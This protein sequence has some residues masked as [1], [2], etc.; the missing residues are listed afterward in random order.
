MAAQARSR[1]GRT[2]I[3]WL[4]A[5]AMLALAETASADPI[6]T[7]DRVKSSVVAVG[8]YERTRS[9]GFQFRAT[10]FSVGDGTLIATNAHVLPLSLDSEHRETLAILV[11][12]RGREPQMREARAIAVDPDTDLALLKI[13]GAPLPA[14]KLRTDG[15]REGQVVLFTG[16]PI[17]AALGIIP[18]THRGMISAITPIAIPTPAA[19]NLDPRIIRRLTTG[20]FMV[21]QLD[22]TAYPGNSGS[23][24]YDPDTGEVFAIINMVFVKSTRESMLKDPSGITYA[25]PARHLRA[26]LE[27]AHG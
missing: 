26:L 22:A 16:F 25:I 9:P 4:F 10:G 1:G 13:D 20:P 21:Y 7:I 24:A 19:S 12:G 27:R 6:A 3:R 8:T 18:A 2:S 15:E 14:L 11:P 5:A 23:P 17:G